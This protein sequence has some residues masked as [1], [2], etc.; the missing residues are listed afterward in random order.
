MR[1]CLLEPIGEIYEAA[2]K[3]TQAVEAHLQLEF[4]QAA[5]L[6]QQ[7][8]SPAIWHWTDRIWGKKSPEIHSFR[9]M[10]NSP[11]RLAMHERPRPRMPDKATQEL[12]IQRDG[13]HCKFCGIPVIRPQVRQAMSRSYPEALPW[14]RS[15]D[16]QHAA[17]QCMWLQF[18]HLLP[19]T[20]GGTSDA[21][22]ILVTCAPC[23]F[24]RMEWTIE[25]AGILDPRQRFIADHWVNFGKWRGL[26]EFL[27]G[28]PLP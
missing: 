17:F 23:N 3:L 9:M 15:N 5:H 24:G 22:N 21:E 13:Y 12:V 20:R 6:I 14:G 18:D 11:P 7:A 27:K 1:H 2:E 10:P 26:E 28:P 25:E 8:N 16:T 19:N 4:D